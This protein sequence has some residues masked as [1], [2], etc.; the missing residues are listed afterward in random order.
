MS[1]AELLAAARGARAFLEAD[2]VRLRGGPLELPPGALDRL[3]RYV[4]SSS[5][6]TTRLN[7]TRVVEPEAVARLHLL[8]ALA[9][10]PLVDD[11]APT[12]AV[13]LGSGGGVPALPL[14]IARDA[15]RWLL[16]DSAGKKAAILQEMVDA[17]GLANVEVARSTR[18][19]PWA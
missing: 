5:R 18:G 15:I 10:L 19:D 9:A 4:P 17:L 3:E 7:L 8:D 12:H 1:G 2:L 14:A 6:P 13:D 16:V 11:V